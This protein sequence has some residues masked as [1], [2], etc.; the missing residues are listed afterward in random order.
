MMKP[1]RW[2]LKPV[3]KWASGAYKAVCSME[4]EDDEWLYK[5]MAIQKNAGDYDT[6]LGM[7]GKLRPAIEAAWR[8][9]TGGEDW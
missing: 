3:S 8:A 1:T 5:V 4:Y 6:A 2:L 7:V 9:L